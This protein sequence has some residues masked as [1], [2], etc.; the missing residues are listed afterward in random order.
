L[1]ADLA[2]LK[3]QS[4]EHFRVVNEKIT[5]QFDSGLYQTAD[6]LEAAAERLRSP[7]SGG[8]PS[9]PVMRLADD[10][11]AAASYLRNQSGHGMVSDVRDFVKGHRVQLLIGVIL[12]GILLGRKLRH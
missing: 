6:R 4:A 3:E 1:D 12:T 2:D 5:D 8:A 10:M 9:D 11:E 7:S